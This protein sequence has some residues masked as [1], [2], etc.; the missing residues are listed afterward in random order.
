MR[1]LPLGL[2]LKLGKQRTLDDD[3][4]RRILT[5][6]VWKLRRRPSRRSSED[7]HGATNKTAQA[8]AN[9]RCLALCR[10]VMAQHWAER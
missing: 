3:L 5:L 8:R 4:Q 1:D 9:S 2:C 7:H 10:N 6:A